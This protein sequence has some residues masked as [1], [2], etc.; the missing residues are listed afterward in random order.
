MKKVIQLGLGIALLSVPLSAAFAAP[1]S[2]GPRLQGHILLQIQ[3][4]GEAWYVNPK[5][6]KRYYMKDGAT[7]YQM[8]R[9]FGLGIT[10]A[11]LAKAQKGDKTVL[12]KIKGQIVLQVES[13]GEA[14]Y[15]NPDTLKLTYMKD[16][17]AAYSLMRFQSLGISDANLNT[18]PVGNISG[19]S[20]SPS[21]SSAVQTQ[22]GETEILTTISLKVNGVST[23]QQTSG[24]LGT[25][26]AKPDSKF[27][28]IDA[29]ITNITNSPIVLTSVP[30][31]IDQKGRQFD[32]Y[33]DTI[34]NLSNYLIMRNLAP[35]IIEQGLLLYEVP[36]D[37]TS[38]KLEGIKASTNQTYDVII[39]ES[40]IH[41]SGAIQQNPVMNNPVSSAYCTAAGE[42]CGGSKARIDFDEDPSTCGYNCMYTTPGSNTKEVYYLTIKNDTVGGKVVL[43][44]L[45]SGT[46]QDYEDITSGSYDALTG[47]ISF[48]YGYYLYPNIQVDFRYIEHKGVISGNKFTGTRSYT[49]SNER[50]TTGNVTYLPIAV[51]DEIPLKS[52]TIKGDTNIYS[53]G[54]KTFYTTSQSSYSGIHIV[55]KWFCSE[56]DAQSSG[57]Q[58]ALSN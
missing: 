8:M 33:S 35:S 7:A 21:M 34:G 53:G 49:G 4:H 1:V 37:A 18:I 29:S 31:L 48:T 14:Y 41:T 44:N 9:Q 16:G 20:Q 17:D 50:A 25:A 32:D 55:E 6:K 24:A 46:E 47:N 10:D 36:S 5:D 12:S 45:N 30:V 13:K 26:F 27:I 38:F 54:K 52:C 51:A 3:Q 58:K 39:P 15:A 43:K 57:Y 2:M 22:I 23:A 11:N 56:Q 28:I 42:N 19:S 40:A